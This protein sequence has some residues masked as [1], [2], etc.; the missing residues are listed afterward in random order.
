[1]SENKACLRIKQGS[2]YRVKNTSLVPDVFRDQIV[3]CVEL[4]TPPDLKAKFCLKRPCGSF[5]YKISD[6]HIEAEVYVDLDRDSEMN[7]TP[8]PNPNPNYYS[9]KHS[10]S[11]SAWNNMYQDNTHNYYYRHEPDPRYSFPWVKNKKDTVHCQETSSWIPRDAVVW[12]KPANSYRVLWDTNIDNVKFVKWNSNGTT[13]IRR[14]QLSTEGRATE[15]KWLDEFSLPG[16]LSV[17]EVQAYIR[18]NI[19]HIDKLKEMDIKNP[20][21]VLLKRVVISRDEWAKKYK[22]NNSTTKTYTSSTYCHETGSWG[23]N[24]I[25]T[26]LDSLEA[27]VNS[28]TETMEFSGGSF[29]RAMAKMD[30]ELRTIRQKYNGDLPVVEAIGVWF[31][32]NPDSQ[33]FFMKNYDSHSPF[34]LM[35][36]HFNSVEQM[37][38]HPL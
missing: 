16:N 17:E 24:K 6:S 32:F 3:R 2:F 19:V 14:Y 21:R 33:T 20:Y 8:T 28:S 4:H 12:V 29:A 22:P 23:S 31:N 37:K 10:I 13:F 27:I 34:Y 26:A 38:E 9:A 35:Y 30:R 11:E 5:T 1:M 15:A 18:D 36:N 7:M 25:D